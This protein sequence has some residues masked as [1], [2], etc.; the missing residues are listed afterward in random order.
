MGSEELDTTRLEEEVAKIG[1]EEAASETTAEETLP[2]EKT[3]EEKPSKEETHEDTTSLKSEEKPKE[4]DEE[5]RFDKHPR[6]QKLKQERDVALDKASQVDEILETIG[7]IPV[8]DI[9]RLAKAGTLLK[10]YPELAEKVQKVIDEHSYG[11][12]ETKGEI[13]N[14]RRETE[15][16]RYELVLDKFDKEI[17]KLMT[18]NKV[19]SELQSLVKELIENRVVNQR[20]DLKDIPNTF[21]KVLNDIGLVGKHTLASY[22]TSKKGESRVPPSPEQKGKVIATK[23]ESAEAIDVIEEIAEGLRATRAEPKE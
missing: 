6:W 1:E 21:K 22:V 10:R 16:I 23:K 8:S 19:N 18:E 4:E 17:D 9:A 11:S 3:P 5:T 20:L 14:L 2:E 13:D 12:E 7:D 15:N